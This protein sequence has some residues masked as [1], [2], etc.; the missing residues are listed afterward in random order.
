M[1]EMRILEI[2]RMLEEDVEDGG[3]DMDFYECG[4]VRCAIGCAVIAHPEW[5]WKIHRSNHPMGRTCAFI[6]LVKQD[7]SDIYSSTRV[8]A[9]V[10]DI[11]LRH[12]RRLFTC[13]LVYVLNRHQVAKMLRNYVR[14]QNRRSARAI[15]RENDEVSSRLGGR[16]ALTSSNQP[17]RVPAW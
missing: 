10:L 5:G 11:P 16:K 3:F 6:C 7:V 8:V 12:V 2:A 15:V 4:T 17:I 9:R 14:R 1:N 13:N